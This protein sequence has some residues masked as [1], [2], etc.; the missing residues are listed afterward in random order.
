MEIHIH[1][2]ETGPEYLVLRR[3]MLKLNSNAE[4]TRS[5]NHLTCSILMLGKIEVVDMLGF[6]EAEMNGC[7]HH[8]PHETS[9]KL[10]S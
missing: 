6:T 3:M 9:I 4:N 10:W 7:N 2:K 5:K 8:T 1:L